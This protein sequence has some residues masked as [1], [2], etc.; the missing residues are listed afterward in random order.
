M[1][2]FKGGF[3]FHYGLIKRVRIYVKRE[4]LNLLTY[5]G[6]L[7][8]EVD[9]IKSFKN[10]SLN[11]Y[12]NFFD[13]LKDLRKDV[14]SSDSVY[15]LSTPSQQNF[16]SAHSGNT[17]FVKEECSLLANESFVDKKNVRV[18]ELGFVQ[19]QKT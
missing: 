10:P 4:L 17:F 19:S 2:Q 18:M 13:D 15:I 9:L 5:L 8:S 3:Y 12:Q 14:D 6:D 7:R 1:I 16:I 11:L